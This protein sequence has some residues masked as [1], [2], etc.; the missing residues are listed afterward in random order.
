MPTA[1]TNWSKSTAELHLKEELPLGKILIRANE[2]LTATV[3]LQLGRYLLASASRP[4]GPPANLQGIW[5]DDPRPPWSSNYT[6]NI[7]TQMN[8]WPS[9]SANLS[10][11]HLPAIRFD[12]SLMGPGRKTAGAYYNAPGWMANHT[13]NPWFQTAPT[14]A[15]LSK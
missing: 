8:Y 12:Q 15:T 10:E 14:V 4:G 3:M 2:T 9:E 7:N 6:I 5:N 13:Q 11:L 1:C